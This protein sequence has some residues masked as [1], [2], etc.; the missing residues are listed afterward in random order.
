MRRPLAAQGDYAS[1]Q[2]WRDRNI[3]LQAAGDRQL[4][5]FQAKSDKAA[6]VFILRGDKGNAAQQPTHK[7][8]SLA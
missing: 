3:K 4:I 8:P 7:F 2:L 5:A 6:G 1:R